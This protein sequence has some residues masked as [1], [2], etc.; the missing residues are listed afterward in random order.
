[1]WKGYNHF[2]IQ[3]D[4]I[5]VCSSRFVCFGWFKFTQRNDFATSRGD[6][7]VNE[8]GMVEEAR[9]HGWTTLGQGAPVK[10]GDGN[11]GDEV[12]S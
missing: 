8:Q 5:P 10:L 4:N 2:L 9:P 6:F 3:K 7:S 11:Q 1:M 12:S